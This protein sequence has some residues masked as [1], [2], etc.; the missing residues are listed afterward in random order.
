MILS[1]TK[2]DFNNISL[3]EFRNYLRINRNDTQAWDI[4]MAR[5]D[6][7]ATRTNFPCPMSLEQLEETVKSN[8]ELKA[9]FD[10]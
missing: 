7:E 3:K 2:P 5:L 1:M 10:I 9:K 4:Y 8:P 6:K